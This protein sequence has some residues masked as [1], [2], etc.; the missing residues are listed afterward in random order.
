MNEWG[1]L[2]VADY[3]EAKLLV[4]DLEILRSLPVRN[5]EE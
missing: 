2:D 3:G 4:V 5:R 1:K